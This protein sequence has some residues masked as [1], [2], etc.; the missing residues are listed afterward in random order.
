M[1]EES[2]PDPEE[3]CEPAFQGEIRAVL[4]FL[5]VLRARKAFVI[6]A[7]AVAAL[8]GALFVFTATPLYEADAELLVTETGGS[9]DVQMLNRGSPDQQTPTYVKLLLSEKVLE[10]AC[11]ELVRREKQVKRAKA[12]LLPTAE[13]SAVQTNQNASSPK[14]AVK[15]GPSSQPESSR[16]SSRTTETED[17][18]EISPARK[19][20]DTNGGGSDG[21]RPPGNSNRPSNSSAPDRFNGKGRPGNSVGEPRK[22]ADGKNE[23]GAGLSIAELEE[24]FGDLK[25]LKNRLSGHSPAAVQQV[26]EPSVLRSLARNGILPQSVLE[27]V[28]AE[29]ERTESANEDAPREFGELGLLQN[30]APSL[31]VDLKHLPRDKWT[32]A[33]R[34]NLSADGIRRTNVLELSYLSKDPAVAEV[35]VETIVDSYIDFVEEHHKDASAKMIEQLES[36]L[37][38][39]GVK[40]KMQE[41]EVLR[42]K[43]DS[44]VLGIKSGSTTEHPRVQAAVRLNETLI[45]VQKDRVELEAQ[46][47]SVLSAI[48]KG[49]DLRQHLVA[50]KPTIGRELLMNDLGLSPIAV[51][52]TN[53]TEQRIIE[54]RAKLQTLL[55]HL[56][57]IHPEVR[58]L[59]EEIQGYENYLS[60]Y[61]EKL[62]QRF[63]AM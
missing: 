61:Q 33:L 54:K 51:E 62:N 38:R 35:V 12:D 60:A 17:T 9:W 4:R 15:D 20:S 25:K 8:L 63:H 37:E 53:R 21:N 34:N 40:L 59:E 50:V 55:T 18:V 19:A 24:R 42:A 44:G 39:V 22:L 47:A 46:L 32:K 5:R 45:D 57:P 48:Q 30:S 56:G 3:A 2:R 41:V 49:E 11:Q 6:A 26:F 10:R 27:P 13:K 28:K 14:T 1:N 7:V 36:E 31:L 23:T 58:Q 29:K 52:N 43:T 16:T